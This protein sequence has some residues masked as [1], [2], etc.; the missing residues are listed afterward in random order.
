MQAIDALN[1]LNVELTNVQRATTQAIL[2]LQSD[3]IKLSNDMSHD[4]VEQATNAAAV[5][6]NIAGRTR[7][8]LRRF[9]EYQVATANDHLR[10]AAA[11]PTAPMS[12]GRQQ[13]AEAAGELAKSMLGQKLGPV[14]GQELMH[15]IDSILSQRQQQAKADLVE[16]LPRLASGPVSL[17]SINRDAAQESGPTLAKDPS[18]ASQTS[19]LEARQKE[20]RRVALLELAL[21]RNGLIS[22]W[23]SS[24]VYNEGV[25]IL[26]PQYGV[27]LYD[28]DIANLPYERLVSWPEGFYRAADISTFQYL[29]KTDQIIMI[30]NFGKLNNPVVHERVNAVELYFHT[31]SSAPKVRLPIGALDVGLLE[32]VIRDA[33]ARLLAQQGQ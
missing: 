30:I 3:K 24:G 8:L 29:L 32:H 28:S 12:A 18:A 14:R 1:K 6:D 13:I 4:V 26:A 15:G 17:T 2:L 19:E 21:G 5:L 9:A 31:D 25:G 22:Q 20:Q 7:D 33:Q 11:A 23:F 27:N 10:A 16:D